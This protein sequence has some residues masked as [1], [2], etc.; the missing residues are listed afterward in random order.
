MIRQAIELHCDDERA[1]LALGM[2]L[3]SRL[4]PP[5]VI[6]LTGPLGAGKTCLVRGLAEGLGIDPAEVSSPTFVICQEYGLER[7]VTLAHIDAYRLS[8]P[9][10]LETIGFEELLASDDRLLAIEWAD[11]IEEALPASRIEVVITFGLEGGRDVT[12]TADR[13]TIEHLSEVRPRRRTLA[14]PICDARVDTEQATAPFCSERAAWS[15]SAA[16]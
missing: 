5:A 10:E 16:G 4:K 14:C 6:A 13:K 8:S 15:I 9:E 7:A 12:I 1:T 3:A 2:A 11:R